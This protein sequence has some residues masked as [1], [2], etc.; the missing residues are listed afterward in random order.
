VGWLRGRRQWAL[1]MAHDKPRPV[2][3]EISRV[4]LTNLGETLAISF[5]LAVA[6]GVKSLAITTRKR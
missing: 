6:T 2:V 1:A 4:E 5:K 3:A